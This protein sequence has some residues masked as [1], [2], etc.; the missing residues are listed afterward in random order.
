VTAT[1]PLPVDELLPE[2][3][4]A[5]SRRP[6]A[7]LSAPPG[8]G[9]TT[10]V[11]PTL[12]AAGAF[13]GQLLILQPRRLAARAVA[14]QMAR[15]LGEPLGETVGYRVRFDER[16]S[17]RTRILVVTEGILTRR[18]IS[19]PL[20]E[21]VGCVVLDEFHE[22]SVDLDLCLAFLRESLR[23]RDDLKLVI[24]SATLDPE[25]LRAFLQSGL[26]LQ[27]E[28]RA[29]PVRIGY[30]Q[31]PDRRPLAQRVRS[32][33]ASLIADRQDDGGDVLCF[34]PGA[35]EIRAAHRSLEEASL[36]GHP[37][38]VELFGALSAGEQDRALEV[39]ERRRGVL[40]TNI[41]E[42]SLTVPGVTAVVDSG[43]VKRLRYDP[44]VGLDRLELGHISRASA[45]QRAGRAGRLGP[46]RVLR[47]WSAAEQTGLPA[48]DA[49]EI[50]RVDAAPVVL[51]VLSFQPGDPARF[52]FFEAPPA[53]SLAAG[54]T[55]LRRLGALPAE[56][57]V[58]TERGRRLAEL[59]L[60]PRLGALLETARAHG[61][62]SEGALL[63]ALLAERDL[64]VGGAAD[65]AH[66]SDLL[67]RRDLFRAA[68]ASGFSSTQARSLG[69]DPRAAGEVER[70]AEQLRRLSGSAK[71]PKPATA[72]DSRQ[73]L[74]IIAAAYPDR[75]CRRRAPGS[76]DALMVGGRGVQ[77]SEESG[78]RDAALFVVL[79]ADAG[80]PG[81]HAT[82]QVRQASAVDDELLS[83]L[84]PVELQLQRSVVFDERRG[85]VQGLERRLFGDLVI[86]ERPIPVDQEQA[87][88]LLLEVAG[89]RF[90]ELLRPHAVAAQALARLRLAAQ[91][92]PEERWPDAS[93]DGLRALLPELCATRRS[94]DEL[95]RVDWGAE[96]LRR[97]DGRQ[98]AL[99]DRELPERLQVP[100]GNH[101]RVG[102]ASALAS[103]TA[104][105]LAVKLQEL[106]GLA[107]SPRLA[108]GRLP[109][110][111][112]LLAPNGRPVQ[113][114]QDLASFWRN[115]YPEVRRTLRGRYPKHPWPEDPWAAVPTARTRRK[116]GQE[117]F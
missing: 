77:L 24:M 75:V 100:S 65:T 108:R 114:T 17:T 99:L 73:L 88:R 49:P 82:A 64:L 92:L 10:R 37:D 30:L 104:P 21:G 55:L 76:R 51:A 90:A 13:H 29:H 18:L 63:A 68:Q 71:A 5:L 110:T 105:V 107:E 25:P 101:I 23:A 72:P 4:A 39:G 40:A 32:A 3:V 86:S 89:A 12:L 2:L 33:V 117:P 41:A 46:G 11:P 16:V 8:A 14:A 53:A 69:I 48:A 112:H 38:I 15:Q 7:L 31:A 84:F 74:R 103:G 27:A 113:V 22:R 42:T 95:R 20:L 66:D 80:R 9:K 47:L 26:L 60:H 116:R 19:D 97:L 94:L 44:R 87:S 85:L 109:V 52:G 102:Y 6:V 58:L 70:A 50:Q 96:L 56:G 57:F 93:E 28:Q 43:L 62:A 79:E 115:G 67:H 81:L 78:V 106:F 61:L 35:G 83:Q 98:R 111:V 54:L 1:S 45:E 91:H 59:P 36:R 34:L